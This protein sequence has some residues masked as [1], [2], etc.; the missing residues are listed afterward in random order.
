M[1]RVLYITRILVVGA[2]VSWCIL[3]GLPVPAHA[4]EYY[5]AE[6]FGLYS[7]GIEYYH[8]GRLREAKEVLERSVRLD[9][10]ND[11]AQGY[12]DLVNAELSM[13]AKGR[14]DF[15]QSESDL[16][17]ESD[18]EER[19]YYAEVEPDYYYEPEPE[20]EWEYEEEPGASAAD[21]SGEIRMGIG[22]TSEDIVWKDANGD[23]IGVPF[24]KN[25]KYLW[26]KDRHNT[27]DAKI[28]DRLKLDIDTGK[29]TGFNAYG[30][31]VIDPWTFVGKE[32]VRINSVAPAGDK[33]D[34][35]LKYWS[36]TRSTINE[37]YRSNKG[38]IITL[39]EIKI[40]DGK[41]TA[42]IPT[43][44]TDWATTFNPVLTGTEI[45][46]RYMP[47]R[48][49]WLDY[50][51][52]EEGFNSRVFLMADQ[53]EA[54]TSDDPLRL[55]NNHVYWEE[56][57][58]LDEYEPSRIFY[59]DS[60]LEPVKK[61]RWIRR[62]S[63]FAKDSYYDDNS[64]R[65]VFLRGLS[66]GGRIYDNTSYNMTVAT[67]MSLWDDYEN[68]TSI[69]LALRLKSEVSPDLTLGSVYTFKAG[70]D[71]DSLEAMNN[72]LGFDA[73]YN[74]NP[75]WQV[76]GEIAASD[77]EVDEANGK[78]NDYDGFAYSLGFKSEPARTKVSLSYMAQDFY[79]ALSN[80]RYTR[81]DQFYSKHIRFSELPEQDQ[82][83]AI[84]DGIDRGRIVFGVETTRDFLDEALNA[85][86]N[87]RNV[88][89]DSGKYVETVTRLE[90]TY[91]MSPQ[92]TVKGLALYQHLPSTTAGYDP[93][94]YA[95]TSYGFT[96][97]YS[98]EDIFVENADVENGKDPSIGTFSL[99]ARYDF[100]ENMAWEG[101]YEKTNDPG[102]SPR[103]LLNDSYVS[104]ET[105][106]GMLL[107][108]IIPFLYDQ[109]MF[110]MPPYDYYDIYKT[111][112]IYRPFSKLTGILSFTRNVNKYAI[113][114]DDNINHIGLELDYKH[115]ER[116][117]FGFKYI[118]SKLKDVYR[119]SQEGGVHYEG[120]HNFFAELDYNI[121]KD[122]KF[123]LLFGEF[124]AYAPLEG[125]YAPAKWSLSALD[126]QHIVRMFYNRKF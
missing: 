89:G 37:T 109:D 26:G 75:E 48:K 124:V 72:V 125:L 95:K 66:L 54:L 73:A 118:Y 6:S 45:D 43:G 104:T 56:S 35:E 57:P 107:D 101:V 8:E 15:Y 39:D 20:W 40:V 22:F 126:T 105:K 106:G 117:T 59:P 38:N 36:N 122:Q 11:E 123:S 84:G 120:H 13:R 85:K 29:E 33:V 80:Y 62:L 16:R 65:L 74:L 114:L 86:V 92:L 60:G 103:A 2:M 108:K 76:F 50:G 63:F 18:F 19:Q 55:S 28:F 82:A 79:P 4:E 110:E 119:Q 87:F 61:G 96:D 46:R 12:L 93:L 88:H 49:L 81:R 113:G 31:I 112:L 83:I 70:M 23:N 64:N 71:N 25:W 121:D 98:E 58:W 51:T 14:L 77:T 78:Q 99:G 111:K 90:T 97:Y 27:Y 41:T 67:P 91:A 52:G 68:V 1:R 94:I 34:I 24:E 116:L 42:S 47:F 102:D 53:T 5:I 21:I 32:D 44:I 17:R 69:P 30:Q 3:G 9:P 100:S 115:N 7:K 10:R